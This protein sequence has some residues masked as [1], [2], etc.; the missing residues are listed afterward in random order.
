MASH[1]L[2]VT[3]GLI[4]EQGGIQTVAH[5][6]WE[7]LESVGPRSLVCFGPAHAA[8][9]RGAVRQVVASSKLALLGRLLARRWPAEIGLF[10]HLELLK[11]LPLLR[12]GPR[13]VVAFLHGVEAWR[14]LSRPT[15]RLLHRVDLFLSNS[16]HTWERFL[17]WQ[18]DCAKRRHVVVPLGIAAAVQGEMPAP[19]EPPTGLILGRMARGEDYKGHRELIEAWPR[20][21]ACV[22]GARLWV[23]GDGDLRPELEALACR[24]G[25]ES[26]VTFF[27]RVDEDVKAD[28]LAR[29]RCL[30]MPSRGEGFGL[31]YLEAMRMGRPCLVS[32]Q[33]AGREVVNPPEAGL[34]A[35]PADANALCDAVVRLLTPG[36][37]WDTWSAAAR[38]RYESAFTAAHFQSRLLEALYGGPSL[39]QD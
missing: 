7:A 3:S 22:P 31:V 36:L 28:L 25:A 14:A 24:R 23:A 16:Q 17:S 11:L 20:V 30:L 21:R 26:G 2:L 9:T 27:G 18:S 33:D 32:N 8:D 1:T 35:D 10:L 6:T 34:A 39:V 38:R 19:E 37:C 12:G 4:P 15:Q 5:L 13:Q 29:A